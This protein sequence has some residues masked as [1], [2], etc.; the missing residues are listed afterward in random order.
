MNIDLINGGVGIAGSLF[1][2]RSIFLLYKHKQ[3]RGIFWP[4]AIFF[5]AASTWSG[6]FFYRLDMVYSFWGN[7]AYAVTNLTWLTL[8]VIYRRN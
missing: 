6:Y 1:I 4:I 8:A 2:I 7:V 3:V 5:S